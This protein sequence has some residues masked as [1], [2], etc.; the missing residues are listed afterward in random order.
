MRIAL[1]YRLSA[2]AMG[3]LLASPMIG[4]SETIQT[5]LPS[6]ITTY[7]WSTTEKTPAWAEQLLGQAVTFKAMHDNGV[8]QGNYDPYVEI[9]GKARD[10]YRLGDRK[11]TYDTVNQFMVMLE[12]RVG[13][14]DP[15]AGDKLWD[16]CYRWTPNEYHDRDKHARAVG[17]EKLN[18]FEEFIRNMDEKASLSF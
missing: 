3:F 12:A 5:T 6:G 13:D 11:T 8:L 10:A 14:I 15:H 9:L 7:P 1:R 4:C 18:Q 16:E 2:L 17:H